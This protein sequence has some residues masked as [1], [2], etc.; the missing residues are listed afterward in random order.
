MPEF[1]KYKIDYVDPMDAIK[2]IK[3]WY[4]DNTRT[5]NTNIQQ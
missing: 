3:K 4:Y 1:S 2:Q 5:T